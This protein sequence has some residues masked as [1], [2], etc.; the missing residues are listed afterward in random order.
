M[1]TL[2]ILLL[3]GTIGNAQAQKVTQLKEARVYFPKIE[4]SS[5]LNNLEVMVKEDY[6][7]QFSE[8]PI[9]FMETNFNI[10]DIIGSLESGDY[11]QI[12]VTFKSRKGFLLAS[13]D[14][15]GELLKT[16]QRFNDIAL[17]NELCR[18]LYQNYKGYTIVKNKYVASGLGNTINKHHYL[19]TL[20]NGNDKQRVKLVPPIAS[21]V[22]INY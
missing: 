17:P 12:D 20:K 2:I 10:Q 18:E 8:N 19:V 3:L 13:F 15:K 16:T 1:K 4:L 22:A 5:N 6:A 21:G 11:D 9:K 7:G 14:T